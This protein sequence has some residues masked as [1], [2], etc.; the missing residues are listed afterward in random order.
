MEKIASN[1]VTSVAVMF[2]LALIFGIQRQDLARTSFPNTARP[3]CFQDSWRNPPPNPLRPCPTMAWP[4][5]WESFWSPDP[6]L[7]TKT[8]HLVSKLSQNHPLPLVLG[9]VCKSLSPIKIIRPVIIKPVG[10][11]FEIS[12]SNPIR[13]KSPK[14]RKVPLTLQKQGFEETPRSKNAENAQ[15]A[16]TKTRKMRKMRLTGF[17]V[18]GFR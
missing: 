3:I 1:P 13:G 5:C 4:I 12:D 15:N 17:N 9:R 11:I 14:M 7:P 2:F 18:T 8:T 10:R 6:A 16:D